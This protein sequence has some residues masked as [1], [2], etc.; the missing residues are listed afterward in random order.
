MTIPLV[1]D[2]QLKLPKATVYKLGNRDKAL[3]DETFDKLHAEGKMDWAKSFT[4]TGYSVFVVYRTTIAKDGSIS[5]K[6][7]VFVDLRSHNK[8]AVKDTYP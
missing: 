3:V 4:P 6:G 5:R 1:P 7:R 8:I 2:W